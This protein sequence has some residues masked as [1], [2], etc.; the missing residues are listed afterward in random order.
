[1]MKAAWP[2]IGLTFTL[3]LVAAQAGFEKL[4]SSAETSFD[5]GDLPG[6]EKSLLAAEKLNPK[7][8]LVHN[9]LGTL[10]LRQ[11][12]YALAVKEFLS[13]S[14]LSPENADV[15]RN[16][17]TSYFLSKDYSGALKPLTRA[18]QLDGRTC[19]RAINSVTRC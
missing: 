4:L 2:T 14:A 1:M 15:A 10:Y 16:L 9:N 17:G 6:A 13:A 3:T 8:F 12:R 11:R 7:S 18:K 19:G 5:K